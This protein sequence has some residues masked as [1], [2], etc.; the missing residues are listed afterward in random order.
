MCNKNDNGMRQRRC[1]EVRISRKKEKSQTASGICAAPEVC[2]RLSLML[3]ERVL[4][5]RLC[6]LQ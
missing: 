4:R 1:S 3:A 6:N 5:R 2:T